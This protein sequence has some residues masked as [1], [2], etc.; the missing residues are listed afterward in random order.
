MTQPIPPSW[1][2]DVL[3]PDELERLNRA[4]DDLIRRY[5][6]EVPS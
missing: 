2:D 6:I 4:L 3:S 1:P 5:G